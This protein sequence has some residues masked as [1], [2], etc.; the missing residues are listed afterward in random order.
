MISLD[1]LWLWYKQPANY[2]LVAA[3]AALVALGWG[4]YTHE[5]RQAVPIQV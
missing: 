5:Q 2:G 4:V 1:E 3:I